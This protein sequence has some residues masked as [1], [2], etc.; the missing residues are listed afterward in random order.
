MFSFDERLDALRI[1][2]GDGAEIA[3]AGRAY[4]INAQQCRAGAGASR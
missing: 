1:V 2:L 3:A 4:P